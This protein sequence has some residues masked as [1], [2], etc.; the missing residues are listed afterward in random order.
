MH[1][2]SVAFEPIDRSLYPPE[3]K[4][5]PRVQKRIADVLLKGTTSTPQDTPK[6]WAL[7]FLKAPK[8]MN[9]TSDHLSSITFT[10]QRFAPDADAFD[11]R[12]RVVPTEDEAMLE[13]SLAFRS[14]GYKSTALPG[15]SDLGIPFDN[16]LGIIPN[17][18]YGRVITPS[19]GPGNLTA[20]HIPGLYCAGW[21]KRGPTGVI[22]S[23]MN[24]AF[25][26]ADIIA[27]DWEANVPFLNTKGME[28]TSTGVG[29]DGVKAEV[30]ANGVRPLNWQDWK[31]IDRAERER[32]KKKGKERE[33]FVSIAE[34]LKVLDA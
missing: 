12:A 18:V 30:M 25:A 19:V 26:S 6:S 5:L 28:N 33:K 34:M 14:V 15:L 29:W 24:D 1:I 7:D 11:Q 9:A 2:P 27:E 23:T 32:G 17:D 13:A 16:K 20:G 22:A 8:S 4:K 21:V 10:K 3:V 31:V